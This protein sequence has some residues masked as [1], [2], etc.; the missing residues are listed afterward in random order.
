MYLTIPK[1]DTLSTAVLNPKTTSEPHLRM[2]IFCKTWWQYIFFNSS[3]ALLYLQQISYCLFVNFFLNY[4]CNKPIVELIL[5]DPL[6]TLNTF[7]AVA[8]VLT[9][10]SVIVVFVK[11]KLGDNIPVS[12]EL[13]DTLYYRC[14]E[15]CFSKR[16]FPHTSREN[17]VLLP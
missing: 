1:F 6:N 12:E 9:I 15:S 5:I 7:Y 4:Y 10:L 8:Y 17:L 14:A 3:N 16:S 2:M 13:K 11:K